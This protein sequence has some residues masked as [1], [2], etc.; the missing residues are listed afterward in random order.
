[1]ISEETNEDILPEH[2]QN[3]QGWRPGHTFVVI[4]RRRHVLRES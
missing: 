2:I 1:M 4:E 3:Y